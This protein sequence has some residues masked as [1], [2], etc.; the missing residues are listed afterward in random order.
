MEDLILPIYTIEN[1]RKVGRMVIDLCHGLPEAA[2]E[3]K[4][5]SDIS[6]SLPLVFIPAKLNPFAFGVLLGHPGFVPLYND[7][8]GCKDL[9]YGTYQTALESTNLMNEL[10][11]G[12]LLFDPSSEV[13]V[14]YVDRSLKSQL[15]HIT[16]RDYFKALRGWVPVIDLYENQY[17][18]RVM[19]SKSDIDESKLELF[20]S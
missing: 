9:I 14:D 12:F 17:N 11:K 18:E 6:E 13:I 15:P 5:L 20:A 2:R 3:A 1:A 10:H 7:M 16:R 19:V 4:F 8:K